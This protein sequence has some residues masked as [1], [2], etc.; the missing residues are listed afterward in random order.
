V[1]NTTTGPIP[2]WNQQTAQPNGCAF[3]FSGGRVKYW[4]VAVAILIAPISGAS[5]PLVLMKDPPSPL[6]TQPTSIRLQHHLYGLGLSAPTL[7]VGKGGFV[8]RQPFNGLLPPGI[9]STCGI[10]EPV[11]LGVLPPGHYRITWEFHDTDSPIVWDHAAFD[12]DV[13]APAVPTLQLPFLAMLAGLIAAGGM[14]AL[15]T[16]L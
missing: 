11:T 12:L 10:S 14:L 2:S 7:V 1:L 6:S 5:C 3:L 9:P 4:L 16:R 15:R 13:S 8:V